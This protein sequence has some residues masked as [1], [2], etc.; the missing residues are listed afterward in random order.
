M[1]FLCVPTIRWF[2]PTRCTRGYSL[3]SSHCIKNGGFSHE[4]K[5]DCIPLRTKLATKYKKSVN[6][7]KWGTLIPLRSVVRCAR[8]LGAK[9]VVVI[10]VSSCFVV[11][12]CSNIHI[13][14]VLL[15]LTT[16]MQKG[17]LC[18]LICV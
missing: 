13:L 9:L 8:S 5:G 14:K 7:T 15:V 1:S 2:N 10:D 6:F 11:H 4:L 17:H 18:K 16:V 12:C 3:F